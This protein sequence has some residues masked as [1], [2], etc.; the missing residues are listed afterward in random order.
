M[1]DNTVYQHK[2]RV[3]RGSTS[4]LLEHAHAG[5]VHLQGLLINE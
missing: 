4:V 3:P 5:K 1:K 2:S